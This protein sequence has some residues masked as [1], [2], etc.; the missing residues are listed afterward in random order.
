M[1]AGKV[2]RAFFVVAFLLWVL[3]SAP[4]APHAGWTAGQF[5]SNGKPVQEN[6]CVPAG[7]GPFPVVIMLH[8]SG[9]RGLGDADVE[10]FCSKLAE[11][12][13]YA[14]FVEYYSQAAP[15]AMADAAGKVR[16]FPTWIHEVH[17]GI[18]ALKQN[19][20]ADSKRVALIGY[21][22]GAFIALTY[23]ATYPDDVVA[24]VDYYG[25]LTPALYAQAATMPP[26]LILHGDADRMVPVSKAR[27]LDAILTK[28]ARP[29]EIRIYP[30]ASHAFNFPSAR[31]WYDQAAADDSWNRSF[32]FL[33]TYLK[34]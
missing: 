6:H 29:H 28:A 10:D 31:G 8:G 21:S 3:P 25:G 20:A 22:L 19:P 27:D 12:G 17:S 34:K 9:R 1:A 7:N 32:K 5:Q 18:A 15:A 4:P 26:V 13:Y 24:I 30:G 16:N 33:D 14:E 23:G 11:H 2:T